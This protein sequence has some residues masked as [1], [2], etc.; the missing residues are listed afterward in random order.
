[1]SVSGMW[2]L[3][4]RMHDPGPGLQISCRVEGLQLKDLDPKALYWDPVYVH[5]G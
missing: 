1:M 3:G 5:S 4:C 2:F